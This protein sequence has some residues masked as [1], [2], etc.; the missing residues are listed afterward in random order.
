MYYNDKDILVNEFDDNVYK[1]CSIVKGVERYCLYR[2]VV[3]KKW[4]DYFK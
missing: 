1:V 4:F 3:M 2:I